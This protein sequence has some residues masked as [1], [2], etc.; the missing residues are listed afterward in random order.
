[1]ILDFSDSN[2]INV[3]ETLIINEKPDIIALQET[4]CPDCLT[5]NPKITNH[6]KFTKLIASSQRKGYSGVAVFSTIEPVRVLEDFPENDEGRV[7]CL[8]YDKWYIIN[9]YV[10]NSKSDLSRLPYRINVWEKTMRTYISKLQ[11]HKPVVYVGDMKVAPSEL[12]IWNAKSNEKS[13]G[14]TIEERDAF[15]QML[16]ECNM[17]DSYRV[18]HPTTRAYTWY[19]PFVKP[20]N[21]EKGWFIDKALVSAKLKKHIANA[22]I[23]SNYYG[24]DH[25]PLL[26][27]LR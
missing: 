16:R 10:P 7:I 15:A 11:T 13:N 5:L 6:Y 17:I 1:L 19:S 23:L 9:A 25:V 3:L 8:E 18:L 12:D 2:S 21:L 27:E 22:K 20:R 26:L 4:K 24:S 14:Y